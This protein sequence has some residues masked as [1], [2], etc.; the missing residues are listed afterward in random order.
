MT[1]GIQTSPKQILRHLLEADCIDQRRTGQTC[2]QPG[3]LHSCNCTVQQSPNIFRLLSLQL[4]T[5]VGT[6]CQ[7]SCSAEANTTQHR[8]TALIRRQIATRKHRIEAQIQRSTKRIGRLER[9]QKSSKLETTALESIDQPQIPIW[10][11]LHFYARTARRV[12]PPP[13]AQ[14]T[15]KAHD[16]PFGNAVDGLVV[17]P[18][19]YADFVHLPMCRPQAHSR[20]NSHEMFWFD[21]LSTAC[22]H[23]SL[24]HSSVMLFRLSVLPTNL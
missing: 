19:G 10:P 22:R 6:P 4:L 24:V 17:Q 8:T 15:A 21:L 2:G 11:L 13:V 9:S 20:G 23:N 5:D 7:A 3:K 14:T 18:L 16:R 12:V 1:P